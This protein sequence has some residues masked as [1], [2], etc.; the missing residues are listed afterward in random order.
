VEQ[1]ERRVNAMIS[2]E[3]VNQGSQLTELIQVLREQPNPP[4]LILLD[5]THKPVG[6]LYLSDF[7][8]KGKI[9]ISETNNN[10]KYYLYVDGVGIFFSFFEK[11]NIK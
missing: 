4:T 1:N 9:V 10:E 7:R 3:N 5:I 8:E 11:K 6:A 2:E